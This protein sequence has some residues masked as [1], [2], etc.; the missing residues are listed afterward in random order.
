[1]IRGPIVRRLKR[2]CAMD[3]QDRCVRLFVNVER[4][5]WVSQCVNRM[6]FICILFRSWR[7]AVISNAIDLFHHFCKPVVRWDFDY[8][9]V[10]VSLTCLDVFKDVSHSV[11]R[12]L[13][14]QGW[15]RVW[16]LLAFTPCWLESLFTMQR[17]RV[18][19][20]SRQ[21]GINK[22][23]QLEWCSRDVWSVTYGDQLIRFRF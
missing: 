11:Y 5:I 9:S 18:C 16:L 4:W 10:V 19:R 2:Y 6:T 3:R 15:I 22:G 14:P 20:F 8:L 1:M 7:Y 17:T 12:K 13:C 23:G 21:D